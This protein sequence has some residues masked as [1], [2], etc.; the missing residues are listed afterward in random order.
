MVVVC[1]ES[2]DLGQRDHCRKKTTAES[3]MVNT[4]EVH[5]EEASEQR[6]SMNS[7]IAVVSVTSPTRNYLYRARA[8]FDAVAKHRPE[9]RGI[10][11]CVDRLD[12]VCD[13]AK[14][15]F[16]IVEAAS[17]GI[18]RFALGGFRRRLVCSLAKRC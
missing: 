8:L 13:P 5:L 11:C 16:E 2:N 3:L 15:A 10:V 4:L 7:N 17:R 1:L 9:V 6:R 18:A 12:G 14:E